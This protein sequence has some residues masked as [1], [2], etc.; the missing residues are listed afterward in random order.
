MILDPRGET[1]EDFFLYYFPS[2]YSNSYLG[3]LRLIHSYHRKIHQ[4]YSQYCSNI[5]LIDQK[6][7]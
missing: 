2:L 7:C 5:I 6:S 1:M 3:F 4:Y